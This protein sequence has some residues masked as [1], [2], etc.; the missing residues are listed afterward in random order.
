MAT[1]GWKYVGHITN[2][3]S[4]S[5]TDVGLEIAEWKTAWVAALA[6]AGTGW[7]LHADVTL[8]N[9]ACWWWALEHTGGARIVFVRGGDNSTGNVLEA[10]NTWDNVTRV[11]G[12]YEQRSWVAYVQPH[13]SATALGTNP[14]AAGFLPSGSLKFFPMGADSEIT[15]GAWGG[16]HAYHIV[17]RGGDAIVTIGFE[18]DIDPQ[19]DTLNVMGECLDRLAHEN[20]LTEPDNHADSKYAHL[21]FDST[22]YNAGSRAQY[23]DAAQSYLFRENSMTYLSALL[24]DDVCDRDP[25]TWQVPTFYV[26]S[27]DLDNDGIVTGNGI[28]GSM[29]PEWMR[30]T[31][32]PG[33][34]AN[35]K[36][37]LDGGD[38][39]Y[40]RNGIAIGWDS[41][42]GSM[43]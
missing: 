12:D 9:S 29:N 17:V 4:G 3:H 32:F 6:L 18:V 38:F 40:L 14:A 30:F 33:G 42:N 36:Q 25:W 21:Q 20:H 11:A 19:V 31:M 28:K 1:G 35:D 41:S 34:P 24:T 13:L 15:G 37:R 26:S 16:P 22:A 23:F 7:S 8:Y 39:I 2:P 27:N 10:S 43:L 5:N